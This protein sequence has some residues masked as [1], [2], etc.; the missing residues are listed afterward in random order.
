MKEI[1]FKAWYDNKIHDVLK[2]DF[3]TH[4]VT[5]FLK[6]FPFTEEVLANSIMQYTGFKDK[7]GEEIYKDDILKI[8]CQSGNEHFMKVIWNEKEGKWDTKLK[9]GLTIFAYGFSDTEKVGNIY[10]NSELLK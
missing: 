7:N 3:C 6:R 2:I 4:F 8:L 5:I 1:K 10:E 9:H